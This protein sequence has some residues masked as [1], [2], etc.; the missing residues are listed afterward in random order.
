M[1]HDQAA[2]QSEYLIGT[3]S[4]SIRS[5]ASD[6]FRQKQSIAIAFDQSGSQLFEIATFDVKAAAIPTH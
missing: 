6:E 5:S 1:F 3:E 4:P 2:T